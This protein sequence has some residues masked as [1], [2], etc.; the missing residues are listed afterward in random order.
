MQLAAAKG[1]QTIWLGVWERNLR[2]QTFY[3]KYG[4][5]VVGQHIFKLGNDEQIDLIMTRKI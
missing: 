1:F 2:A 5:A 4:F 3:K